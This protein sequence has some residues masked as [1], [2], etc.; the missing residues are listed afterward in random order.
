MLSKTIIKTKSEL[1]IKEHFS[2]SLQVGRG[3]DA[4]FH[5]LVTTTV[6]CK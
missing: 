1:I 3:V 5:S 6:L 2:Y 4:K